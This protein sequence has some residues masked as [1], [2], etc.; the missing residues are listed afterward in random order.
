MTDY[1]KYG[2]EHVDSND[3]LVEYNLSFGQLLKKILYYFD[4]YNN[5]YKSPIVFTNILQNAL[6][7]ALWDS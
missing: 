7:Y 1:L 5:K 4:I 6:L 3:V 2:K